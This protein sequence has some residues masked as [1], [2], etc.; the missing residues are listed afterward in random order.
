[1]INYGDIEKKWQD[2]WAAAKLFEAE[3]SDR[4][5]LLVTA[6]FPYV[7]APPHMG[8]VRTYGT[9][10]TYA[11]YMRMRGF[12][13]LYPFGF[14]ATGT[15]IL[16]FAKRI[17]RG[18]KEI[19]E[20]LKV[21]HVSDA[22]VQKMTSPQ[23][24]ADY[25]I[26]QQEREWRK[27][28]LGIDWRRKF[29]STEPLF[30]K[31]VEWQFAKLKEKGYLTKG[32]HPVGWCLSENQAVGQHDTKGDV[33]PKIE[34]MT[35]IKFRDASGIIFPCA[36][37]RPETVYGVTNIFIKD[38]STYVI[39]TIE[40][41]KYY[42]SKDA[43][44][45]L[46]HQFE[47]EIGGEI[48]SKD[49]LKKKAVNPVTMEEIPVLP[50]FFVKPDVGTG[51]VMSVPS[52]A[53]FDYA[54]L[55]RLKVS[56][57]QL[58][59]MQYKK[60]IDISGSRMGESLEEDPA[61]GKKG[62]IS[63]PE[64]PALAYLELM[65]AD[66]NA[67]DDVLERATKAIYREESRYGVMLAGKYSGRPEAEA[68]EALK[69]D[70]VAEKNAFQMY[71]LANPEPVF[72]RDGTKVIVNMVRNQWFINY[73]D[74]KWKAEV[75]AAFKTIKVYPEKYRKTFEALIDWI[76][77]RATERAQGLGT[78]F[79]YN[80]EHIIESLSDSTIY[81][82]FYT[83]VQILR[84]ANVSPEQLKPEFFEYLINTVGDPTS[85]SAATGI[86]E[87]TI[88]KCKESLEYW[89]TNTSRH[90]GP[91]L[92]PNHYLMY[93]YNHVA[94]FPEKFWPKQI[95]VNGFVNY[96]G[97]KMSKSLGNIIPAGDAVDR[98]G[99]DVIRMI[100]IAGGDLDTETEFRTDS[101]SSIASKNEYLVDLIDALNT[102]KGVELEHIDYWLY[103]K[104]NKKVKIATEAMDRL[105]FRQAY[106]E[107]YYN[108][109]AEMRWYIER[110]GKNQLAMRD[111]MEATALMLTPI[112]PHFA[113]ELWHRLGNTTLAAQQQWP[114]VGEG[115]INEKVERIEAI[116]SET[117]EDTNRAIALT[118]KI[119]ANRG[120]KLKEIRIIIAEDW[121]RMAYNMLLERKSIDQVVR[122]KELND[123]NIQTMSKFLS[124]FMGKLQTLQRLPEIISDEAYTAFVGSR[125]YI[126]D[127]FGAEVTI[128]K[129]SASKSAR[130]ERSTV[131]KPSIDIVWG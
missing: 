112:M 4:K 7:N 80:P 15:P 107:I 27:V 97:E 89:Y 57:Y 93:I 17:A 82:T 91:D 21:F 105:E 98:F 64:I 128:E 108:S 123:Y 68:R 29:I 75:R 39:V 31:L 12:N 46:S 42:L 118:S 55:E 78:R 94:L 121:K 83:Y 30:S 110:G 67:L 115:M 69:K 33:Q 104:L 40:G 131:T 122:D 120:K 54:A 114:T 50:G 109:I 85:V 127:R 32:T 58:P 43:A 38:E 116:I 87:A 73:G 20:E 70:L 48:E 96:E 22:D 16:A 23:Y 61:S 45:M 86:D 19:M 113:E 106:T 52:H 11:R 102:M 130:A 26:R 71:T 56:G 37:Y 63:H 119:T 84:A 36:T 5:N 72:C 129:E 103:S 65:N 25:F 60:I 74:E 53:P 77:E 88:K 35:V 81:M 95:V 66:P 44:F 18:E 14:H 117:M 3:P 24:I 111:I 8:H 9:A 62:P 101:A 28:G 41:E 13:V 34:E 99:A 51:V 76:D 92:I 10:D 126:K 100:E 125:D 49:L 90:S 47:I 1:M 59:Q 2:A 6:A 124:Q 79:P